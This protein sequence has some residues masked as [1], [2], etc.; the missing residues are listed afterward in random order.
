MSPK[1]I[2]YA[3]A[4]GAPML[5]AAGARAQTAVGNPFIGNNTL[6]FHASELTRSGAA[7]M[8][9]TFGVVYGHRFGAAEDQN[10]LTMKLQASARPFDDAKSAV[11]DAAASVGVVRDIRLVPALQVAASAGM[12]LMAWSDDATKKDRLEFTIPANAGV[13]YD[14]RIRSATLSPFVMGTIARYDLRTAENDVQQTAHRGWDA[15][16]TSGVSLRLKEVVLS[17]SRI[18]GE[19]GMPN[20][21]RWTFAA[22]ISY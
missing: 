3:A 9:T 6:S 2:Q 11:L 10:R 18:V 5:I 7:E 13:S 15:S 19:Y 21:S 16:Y 8:T 1:L 17:S 4:F 12:G 20:R 14:L 22:G